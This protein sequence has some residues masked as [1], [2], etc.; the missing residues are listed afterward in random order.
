MRISTSHLQVQAFAA[1]ML[2]FASPPAIAQEAAPTSAGDTETATTAPK[3]RPVRTDSPRDTLGTFLR[4]RDSLE[5]ALLDYR[6]ARSADRAELI[7]LL[8]A[9]FR[10]L[11]APF[12]PK[13]GASTECHRWTKMTGLILRA[14][15]S[16]REWGLK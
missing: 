4:L 10:A 7:F 13:T 1:A 11:L 16:D 3:I 9:Q 2:V 6:A 8:V 5:T 14:S 12:G 15:F